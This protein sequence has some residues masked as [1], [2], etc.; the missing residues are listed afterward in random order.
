MKYLAMLLVVFCLQAKVLDKMLAVIDDKIITKSMIDRIL[1][2]IK[3]R[4]EISP[5]IYDGHS[6]KS[7][8]LTRIFIERI[9]IRDKLKELGIIISDEEVESNVKLT[10]ERLNLSRPA[11]LSFLK[12]NNITFDEYFELMRETIEFQYF[13]AKIIRPLINITDQ[14]VKN[15]FYKENIKNKTLAFRYSLVDFYLAKGKVSES[16]LKEFSSV[17]K[18]FQ[19]GS[20]LPESFRELDTVELGNI[21]EDGVTKELK[22]LLKKTDEGAFTAPILMNNQYHVFFVKKKDLVESDLFLRAKER[23]RAQ[24]FETEAK[25]MIEL[26][27]KREENKHYIK[28]FF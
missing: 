21:T 5:F 8:D 26:W 11:L 2:N 27:Y 15:T 16:M 1:D 3:G 19:G 7:Q 25:K 6:F 23:I 4:K 9:L 28:Y 10:E 17:L 20:S 12:S 24:L 13:N 22:E 14:E 18:T